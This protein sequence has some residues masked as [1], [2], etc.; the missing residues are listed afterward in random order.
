MAGPAAAAFS[1]RSNQKRNT[2]THKSKHVFSDI[3]KYSRCIYPQTI[4]NRFYFF[5]RITKHACTY[6]QEKSKEIEIE[7]IKMDQVLGIDLIYE[8]YVWIHFRII[9]VQVQ[10]ICLN[11]YLEYLHIVWFFHLLH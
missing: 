9:S 2:E 5:D 3:Y 11:L 4:W 8:Y 1:F 6:L 10:K 7:T